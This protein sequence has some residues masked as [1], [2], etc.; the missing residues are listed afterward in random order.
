[1]AGLIPTPI[2]PEPWTAAQS[3]AQFAALAKLRWCIFRNAFRRKGGGGELAARIIIFPLLGILA[4]GPVVGSGFG[5]FYLVSSGHIAMLPILTWAIFALWLLVLLNISPPGLSFDVNTIIRFPLSFPRYLTARLFF[6]LLSAAN[7][8]GAL[9]LISADIGIGIAQP[10]LV[11]WSTLL[12]ATFA[13]TNIFFTRMMLVWVERWLSTRRAR[14]IFTA[15]ILF[16][17]LGFQYININF[18]PGLQHGRHHRASTYLPLFRNIFHHIKPI[19]S[20]LPPGL[21]ASSI[22]GI[23]QN[24]ILSAIASLIGLIAFAT[25]FFA[26]YAWR[27]HREFRGENLSEVTQPNQPPTRRSTT[28]A[29]SRPASVTNPVLVDTTRTGTFGLNGTIIAC[30]QKEFIY[31][32]RN[33][34]QLYGFVAPLFMVFLF[35]SRM[36]VSGRFGEF[37]FP[38]AVAYSVLG[39]S[40]LSYN[41]LGMDGTGVQFY[42]LSPTRMRD[43]F[44]AKNLTMFLLTLTELLLIFAVI[45][46]VA[47]APS[48]TVAFA[49]ICWLLFATFINAAIGN[50]RSLIAPRKVDLMKASRKQISQLSALLA[51]GMIAACAALGGAVVALATYLNRPWLMVPIFLTLAVIAFVVYLQVLNRLDAMALTHRES[52]AEELCKA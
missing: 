7:V 25:L 24:H 1:M 47:H 50:L 42:L 16:A 13:L 11:P 40:T 8:I 19:G 17:S 32:R 37:V 35:A 36:S 12:L 33:L 30:L 22:I 23:N 3:R 39:I 5:A 6:G 4:F 46:I 21:T 38:V 26:V 49:T 20:F 45:V 52:L 34:N 31:L 48:L 29:P 41:A 15:F 2:R 43:V 27:M 44:L 18:N 51:L 28:I 10:S 9:A 14:E